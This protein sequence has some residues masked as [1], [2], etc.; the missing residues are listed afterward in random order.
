MKSTGMTRQRANAT[1]IGKK[2]DEWIAAMEGN[3][4]PR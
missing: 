3:I 1:I 4:D 2:L